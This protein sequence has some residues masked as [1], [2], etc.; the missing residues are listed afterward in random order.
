MPTKPQVFGKTLLTTANGASFHA[1]THN[2]L[3]IVKAIETNDLVFINGPAGTGKTVMAAVMAL[4]YLEQ[5]IYE[6]FLITRPAVESGENLG[7]LPGELDEKLAPYMQPVFNALTMLKGPKRPK[8]EEGVDPSNFKGNPKGYKAKIDKNRAAAA[9][10]DKI[11]S[12]YA[13]D[14]LMGELAGKVQVCP[15]GFMRGITFDHAFVLLDEA[16]NITKKQM[17]MFLTRMGE[18]CKV[19]VCGDSKQCDLKPEH[20][21]FEDALVRMQGAPGV[22]FVTMDLKDIVRHNLVREVIIRY[23]HDDYKTGVYSNR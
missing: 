14:F 21:G 8:P 12:T 2:Q 23:A 9:Q 10:G 13:P 22:G 15:L 11:V 3:E 4:K 5:G 20:S 18:D 6:K 19:V 7:Y 17:E 1:K 16:Q